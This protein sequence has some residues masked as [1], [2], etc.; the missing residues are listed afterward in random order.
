MGHPLVAPLLGTNSHG[1]FLGVVLVKDQVF[2]RITHPELMH[3]VLSI[4]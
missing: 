1:D 2:S 4:V 3:S